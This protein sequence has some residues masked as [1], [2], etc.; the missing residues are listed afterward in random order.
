MGCSNVVTQESSLRHQENASTSGPGDASLAQADG[1]SGPAQDLR[2]ELAAQ[3]PAV[4]RFLFGMCGDWDQAEDLAQEALLKAWSRRESFDGRSSPR[5]WIF[6]IARNHWLDQLRRKKTMR[7]TRQ[8][9]T[10]PVAP[11]GGPPAAMARNELRQAVETAMGKLPP[12][13]C[14]AL[15]LRESQALSFEQ[16]GQMLNVPTATVKSRVRYALL[17]LSHELEPF[18]DQA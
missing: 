14:E 13:Q 12:E 10:D 5:T 16:I 8:A 6:A 17:K 1:P 15:A 2:A 4:R 18:Q 11:G 7:L 9:L 3:A